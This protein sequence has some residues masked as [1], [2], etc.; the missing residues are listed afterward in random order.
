[1]IFCDKGSVENTGGKQHVVC[2][3][4]LISCHFFIT[5]GK[6]TE[7]LT[8][9]LVFLPEK[10]VRMRN[11]RLAFMRPLSSAFGADKDAVTQSPPSSFFKVACIWLTRQG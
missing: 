2:P 4:C 9:Q 7:V 5:Q 10:F 1:M 6:M 3:V 8:V 11:F